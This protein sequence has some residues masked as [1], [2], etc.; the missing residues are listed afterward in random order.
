LSERRVAEASSP[1]AAGAEPPLFA[2]GGWS[3]PWTDWPRG[4]VVL[5]SLLFFVGLVSYLSL[6]MFWQDLSY[7]VLGMVAVASVLAGVRLWRPPRPTGWYLLAGGLALFSA[8]DAMWFF[9]DFVLHTGIPDPSVIDVVYLGAYPLLA[10]GL[11]SLA[12]AG[13]SGRSWGLLLEGGIFGMATFAVGWAVL[14]EPALDD[15]AGTTLAGW[16]NVAYPVADVVLLGVLAG[17]AFGAISR[18]RT[19]SYAL[20]VAGVVFQ[21]FG[22]VVFAF[23]EPDGGYQTGHWIDLTWLLSYGL[24]AIAAL[25]PSMQRLTSAGDQPMRHFGRV[26]LVLVGLA[27]IAGPSVLMLREAPGVREIVFVATITGMAALV[28]GRFLALIREREAAEV[29]LGWS[30]ARLQQ[31]VRSS[32]DVI[33][34]LDAGGHVA[35]ANPA[36]A[37]YLGGPGSGMENP[38]AP[39]DLLSLIHPDDSARITERVAGAAAWAGGELHDQ[40]R[41]RDLQGEWRDVESIWRNLLDDPAVNGIVVNLR[42]V[43]ERKRLEH[44]ALEQA[45]EKS[46]MKSAFLANMSHEIRTPMNGVLG[47]AGL[48]LDT[49]LDPSQRE[50]AHM[51]AD[52]AESMVDI[53]NDILDF[54]KIEAGKLDIEQR[55]FDLRPLLEGVLGTFAVRA[56]EK[57]VELVG[58]FAADLPAV[59]RGDR[60]RV[61]QV[62]SNLVVNALKFTK[63]GDVIVRARLEGRNLRF[64]VEDTGIGIH[65]ADCAR[66]FE[67]FEQADASTT[68]IYG[69]SG[70]GLAICTQLVDL[71]GGEIGVT[72]QLGR[73]S[74]FWFTVPSETTVP[75]PAAVQPI[76]AVTV[77]RVL[78]VC[79]HYAQREAVVG[80]LRASAVEVTGVADGVAALDILRAENPFDVV[81]V[82]V[83]AG[84][85]SQAELLSAIRRD[86]SL[87]AVR[88]LALIPPGR[89]TYAGAGCFDGWVTKPPRQATLIEALVAGAGDNPAGDAHVSASPA[90]AGAGRRVLIV[91]DNEVNQRVAAALVE[92]LGYM[93]TAVGDG[94]AALEALDRHPYDAVLMDCQMPRMDGYEATTEIRRRE[95]TDRTPIIAM[96]ASAMASERDRCLAVGMDDH[97]PKPIRRD[98]LEAALTRWVQPVDRGVVDELAGGRVDEAKL[99]ELLGMAPADGPAEPPRVLQLFLDETSNR[100]HRIR[101]AVQAGDLIDAGRAAHSLQGASGLFGARRLGS[102]GAEMETACERQDGPAAVALLPALDSEFEAFR[103][104]LLSRLSHR[105]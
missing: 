42:D 65:P 61:R 102:L 54:S 94:I 37:R 32:S 24:I 70:L 50:W 52:S 78:V 83:D 60:L 96:T 27:A 67:P 85:M 59:V 26:R 68:R 47:M 91:E 35:Y 66:L 34:I 4:P 99:A 9:Y 64:E 16:V 39:P 14:V 72:S 76:R 104:I 5:V 31:L 79:G 36:A 86:A 103:A 8:A 30:E 62:L 80:M 100:L 73:G 56:Y 12:R 45:R 49:E 2:A 101:E 82:D 3:R 53:I 19:W 18:A 48:L 75:E 93:A 23:I 74:V 13:H 69:G 33:A 22:D 97:L 46:R 6:S 84:S 89:G 10:W 51:L 40:F 95:G 77:R 57:G 81:I 90:P 71:M 87:N 43:S 63:E 25:D 7:Q 1:P 98:A 21:L 17:T 58:D 11:V 92:R 44:E 41:L 38:S 29:S 15:A 88:A 28:L 105:G 55:E 20:L